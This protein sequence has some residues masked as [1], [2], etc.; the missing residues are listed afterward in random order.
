ML[1]SGSVPVFVVAVLALAAPGRAQQDPWLGRWEGTATGLQGQRAVTLRLEKDSAGNYGGTISGIRGEMALRDVKLAG[2]T[3]TAES[4]VE[5]AQGSLRVK[6][7][8]VLQGAEL[9]GSSETDFGGQVFSAAIELKRPGAA[10][11]AAA[12]PQAASSPPAQAGRRQSPPQ[13]TQKQ[14]LDY[15]KGRWNYRWVGRESAVTPGGVVEGAIEF[16]PLADSVYLEGQLVGRG[17]WGPMGERVLLGFV[18]SNKSLVLREPRGK[19][20]ETLSLGDWTSP[21]AIRF[22]V[23]PFDAGGRK[24]RLNRTLSVVSAHS[25]TLTEELSEDGGPFVRLG[26]ALFSRPAETPEGAAKD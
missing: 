13:P 24:L 7:K 11:P 2:D 16:A 18:E 21:I 5:A 17:K 15:F 9:K 20:I 8:L 12:A 3:L 25:F 19:G 10:S 6:Y 22:K 4:V 1:R 26:S 14:S 23:A